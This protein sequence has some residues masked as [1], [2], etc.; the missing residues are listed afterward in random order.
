MC[1][2]MGYCGP[3]V[4][5]A[6]KAGFMKTVSRGPDDSRIINMRKGLL[7]FYPL[8]IMGRHPEGMQPFHLDHSY[9]ICNGEIY[10]FEKI[11]RELSTKYSF[12]SDSD[13]K[14]LLPLYKEYGTGMFGM[15]DAEFALIIYDGETGES[16]CGKRPHRYASAVLRL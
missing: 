16:H 7:G 8:M 2:I 11:K 15:L 12:A 3:S 4:K 13:C 10:G 1:S 14:I 6:F 9:V 5:A